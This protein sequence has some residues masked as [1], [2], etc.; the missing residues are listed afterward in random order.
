MSNIYL[1]QQIISLYS[2]QGGSGRTTIALNLAW[3]LQDKPKAKVLFIDLNFSVGQ[4]DMALKMNFPVRPNLSSFIEKIDNPF[5]AYKESVLSFEDFRVQFI[6]PPLSL[7]QSDRFNVDMLNE[8]VYL[9]RNDYDFIVADLPSR[10]DNICMEMLNISTIIYFVSTM[11]S[12]QA[13]RIANFLDIFKPFQKCGLV[14]NDIA[15]ND[16]TVPSRM[17]ILA[18]IPLYSVIKKQE[19]LN[20]HNLAIRGVTTIFPD[21]QNY[22]V[23]L[24]GRMLLT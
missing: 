15:G 22:M 13:S 3:F 18:G 20:A 6:Q 12:V 14:V 19:P 16:G 1:K 4:S 7:L 24:A 9:G 5:L 2:L 10:Y 8:L 23:D 17:E 11:D 21:L